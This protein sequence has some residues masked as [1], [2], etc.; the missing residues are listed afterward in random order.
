MLVPIAVPPATPCRFTLRNRY[1]VRMGKAVGNRRSG[2]FVRGSLVQG[3]LS[4]Q[5]PKMDWN[6]NVKHWVL[7]ALNGW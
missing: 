2:V 7:I 3:S 4:F 1:S 6:S 5:L